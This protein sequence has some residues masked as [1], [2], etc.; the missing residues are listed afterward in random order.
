MKSTVKNSNSVLKTIAVAATAAVLF[1]GSPISSFANT[2]SEKNKTVNYG[3]ESAVNVQYIG[4]DEKMF[5]F[6]VEFE[7]PSAQKFT[8][9]VKNDDG[10]VIYSKEYSDVHFAKTIHLMKEGM[11][12]QNIY[13]TFAISV[14]TRLVQR[15]FSIEKKLTENVIVKSS[16]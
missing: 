15:S 10:T 1:A 9:I 6:K 8:L 5:E 14:G 11:D 3:P 13:P 2:V 12:A 16:K 4:A 7:N